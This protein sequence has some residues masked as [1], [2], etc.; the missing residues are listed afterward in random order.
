MD[1]VVEGV[2]P[3][4]RG[5][6]AGHVSGRRRVIPGVSAGGSS[7]VRWACPHVPAH[8][9][10]VAVRSVPQRPAL[11]CSMAAHRGSWCRASR[12]GHR[13]RLEGRQSAR[14]IPAREWSTIWMSAWISVGVGV[15]PARAELASRS[16]LFRSLIGMEYPC[17]RWVYRLVPVKERSV[18]G[19]S[20]LARG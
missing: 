12:D 19:V 7:L 3:L 9:P 11:C 20:L 6:S 16:A 15:S 2:S 5:N 14:S 1:T 8:R 4:P 13:V 10:A 17:L 18:R